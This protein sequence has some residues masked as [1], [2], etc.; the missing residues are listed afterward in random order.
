MIEESVKLKRHQQIFFGVKRAPVKY[1]RKL[2][3]MRPNY[4]VIEFST[5]QQQVVWR[6]DLYLDDGTP[7][8]APDYEECGDCGFDH[9]YE[10]EET[11]REHALLDRLDAQRN[12][13]FG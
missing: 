11:A 8:T 13:D 10:Q 12:G 6:Q 2:G 3:P 5:G 4:L 9:A 1:V 7:L